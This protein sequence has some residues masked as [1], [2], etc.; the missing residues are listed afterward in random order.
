MA[1][2]LRNFD[3]S[4]KNGDRNLEGLCNTWHEKVLHNH[5]FLQGTRILK[6]GLTLDGTDGGH[7]SLSKD[8]LH[9][10]QPGLLCAAS[11]EGPDSVLRRMDSE[12]LNGLC[13]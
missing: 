8:W 7:T 3:F 13:P 11:T 5:A 2:A 12:K 10:R 9:P 4:P 1:Q 6:Q